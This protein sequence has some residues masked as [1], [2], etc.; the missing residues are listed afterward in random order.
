MATPAT[1]DPNNK[2]E[3]EVVDTK[4]AHGSADL[5]ARTESLDHA[6]PSHADLEVESLSMYE[7]KALIVNREIDALGMGR[8]QWC[9]FFLCGFGYLLDLMW[10]QAFGLAAPALQQELGFSDA[11]LG[12][13]FSSFSAGLTAGAFVWG[14]NTP[15]PATEMENSPFSTGPG[16]YCRKILGLQLHRSFFQRLRLILGCP[17]LLQ[18]HPSSHGVC[19]LRSGWKYTNRYHH[20]S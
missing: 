8:Y 1:N 13:I 20:H 14:V 15:S 3:Y 19:R 18:L 11:S 17:F 7:K 6:A 2:N 10:A 4:D 16:G 12:N 5:E 9:I